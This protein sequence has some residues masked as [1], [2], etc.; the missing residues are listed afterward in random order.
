MWWAL[1]HSLRDSIGT[2]IFIGVGEGVAGWWSD[3][4]RRREP[5]R[6][7]GELQEE[8]RRRG[9]R[10]LAAAGGALLIAALAGAL[11][12]L[13]LSSAVLAALGVGTLI[14]AARFRCP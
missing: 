13:L 10:I 14:W 2:G 9:V 1:D 3:R 4:N 8:Q 7:N 6:L 11:N 5:G 12:G